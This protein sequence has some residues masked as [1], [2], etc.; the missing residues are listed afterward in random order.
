LRLPI[1]QK[2]KIQPI[3]HNGNDTPSPRSRLQASN[4]ASQVSQPSKSV[5]GNKKKAEF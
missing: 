3:A 1:F 4:N 5:A 2:N